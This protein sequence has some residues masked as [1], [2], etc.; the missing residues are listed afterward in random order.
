MMRRKKTHSLSYFRGE[1]KHSRKKRFDPY[2]PLYLKAIVRSSSRE[3]PL[4]GRSESETEDDEFYFLATPKSASLPSKIRKKRR[5]M[6]LFF[7]ER[8]KRERFSIPPVLFFLANISP[9][10]VQKY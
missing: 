4:E 2:L 1:K 10:I 9:L 8:E 6:A 5:K 7:N 3:V